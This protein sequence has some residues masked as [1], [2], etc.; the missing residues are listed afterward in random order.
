MERG[1]GG[2]LVRPWATPEHTATHHT[3]C[4]SS[5]HTKVEHRPS[6]PVFTPV[7]AQCV[8]SNSQTTRF[9]HTRS[10]TRRSPRADPSLQHTSNPHQFTRIPRCSHLRSPT[11]RRP[12]PRPLSYLCKWLRLDLQRR[13]GLWSCRRVHRVS[14]C[15]M[16]TH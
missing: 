8:Y 9:N 1:S 5:S 4:N 6:L 11:V 3:T 16:Q 14:A 10:P 7:P 13:V 2:Y 15:R 12:R